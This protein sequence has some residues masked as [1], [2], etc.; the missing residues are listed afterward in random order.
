[1]VKMLSISG[2]SVCFT[3]HRPQAVPYLW[4]ESSIQ[5]VNL[6]KEIKAVV[7]DLI[8]NNNVAHFISGMAIGVDMISAEIVLDLKKKYPYITIECA[9]PCKTQALKWSDKYRSR[10]FSIIN[11]S[12]KNTVLQ[13]QYTSDCMM[14]RNMYMVDKSDYV[15]AIWNGSPSGTGKTVM[16]AKNKNKTII[17]IKP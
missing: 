10:Y 5:S 12:D 11:Q 6:K 17:Q 15:I 16:Y 9:I 3:G 4:D 2:K 7:I 14:K 8:E 13:T 1:M